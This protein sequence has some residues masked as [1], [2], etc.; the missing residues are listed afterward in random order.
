VTS[1]LAA[2]GDLVDR[3]TIADIDPF[4]R[5]DGPLTSATIRARG[6]RWYDAHETHPDQFDPWEIDAHQLVAPGTT[7]DTWGPTG[8]PAG[9]YPIDPETGLK[10][11][12]WI[13][14]HRLAWWDIGQDDDFEIELA[15][16]FDVD[17]GAVVQLSPVIAIDL[18]AADD[19]SGVLAA[20]DV[21]IFG[22]V[23]YA[24][25]IPMTP[26]IGETFDPTYYY[27][28]PGTATVIGVPLPGQHWWRLRAEAG[29]VTG[30]FDGVERMDFERPAW[31]VS[32]TKVGIHVVGI[33]C[34]PNENYS[35]GL[36]GT[37]AY[38]VGTPG[39]DPP[40]VATSPRWQ[41]TTW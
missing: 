23:I 11:S 3:S 25:V 39:E 32:R 40:P 41:V 18:D 26:T 12:P 8:Y 30:W 24:H 7:R 38:R 35:P 5:A 6:G 17:V 1:L 31:S 33:H 19:E 21:S 14:T 16:H 29:R 34:D 27:A 13:V 4:T 10:Y 20:Y 37:I 22:G 28:I 9:D 36:P 2:N 15:W